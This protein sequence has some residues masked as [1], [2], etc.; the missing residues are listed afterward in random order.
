[1]LICPICQEKLKAEEKRA[2]CPNGHSFDRA[3]EGYF[4]LLMATGKGG[5]GDDKAMLLAR[6]AFLER[7]YYEH[8]LLAL[9]QEIS[10][11]FPENGVFLDAGCGEGYYTAHIADCLKKEGKKPN[12][13]AFDISKDASRLAAKKCKDRAEIFVGSCY[14]MP[15]LSESVDALLSV[16][17]P[18]AGEEFFRVLKPG[19]FLFCAVPEPLHLFELKEAVYENPVLNEKKAEI[20]EG[21]SLCGER[22]VEKTIF[23]SDSD[24]IRSLFAMTPYAHKTSSEDMAKLEK[25]DALSVKTDFNILIYQKSF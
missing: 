5:H 22:R 20:G 2:V 13:F 14:R 16:F 18:F 24:S 17:S 19:G 6:R 11:R 4:N 12:V 9:E 7:G 8:L 10:A 25:L 1:M 21:L 23:L 15:F 3:K